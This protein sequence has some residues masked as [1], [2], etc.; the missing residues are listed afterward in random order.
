M[1]V[2][3]RGRTSCHL[4]SPTLGRGE[5]GRRG[6]CCQE[7][8][9]FVANALSTIDPS[10]MRA[11]RRSV[12]PQNSKCDFPTD[13]P[14]RRPGDK[15]GPWLP[16]AKPRPREAGCDR[17]SRSCCAGSAWG[18]ASA[19]SRAGPGMIADGV[20]VRGRGPRR[21][22]A[23]GQSRAD[24]RARG[25]RARGNSGRARRSARG[26]AGPPRRPS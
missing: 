24:R 17:E 23:P 14:H 1:S 11:T 15:T 7:P 10:M 19:R 12:G 4:K 26:A 8:C 25:R 2:R 18:R 5:F 20:Q 13:T 3:R 21:R 9:V 16:P 6:Y 22:A